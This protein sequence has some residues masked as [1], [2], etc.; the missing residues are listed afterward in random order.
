M[1]SGKIRKSLKGLIDSGRIVT[2]RPK[3]G[4]MV[5]TI[6][7]INTPHFIYGENNSGVGRGPGNPGDV[8]G[9]DKNKGN[10]KGAGDEHADG[11]EVQVDMDEV[12]DALQEEW[13]L[14]DLLPKPSQTFEDIEIKYNDIALIGPNSL[15]HTRRTVQQALKRCCAA[16]DG[17]NLV[18]LPNYNQPIRD[19]KIIKSDQRFRQYKEIRKPSS[20]AVVMFARDWSGSMDA[21]R[22][23]VVSDMCWWL[24]C[25][26]RRYYKRVERMYVGH[27]TNAEECSEEKFYKYRMGGGTVCSSALRIIA[28]Q[29]G[30]RFPPD[31]WNIYVF[32]FTDGDNWGSDNEQFVKILKEEFTPGRVNLVGITQVMPWSYDD[33]VKE[34]VDAEIQKKNLDSKVVKTVSIGSEEV[35]QDDIFRGHSPKIG[36]EDRNRAIKKAIGELLGAKA[37]L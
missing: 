20:N 34:Y 19:L 35:D 24:D 32:Y 11:I 16:G 2:Q 21:F 28:D 9:K 30:N 13:K 23:E 10:S 33:S 5:I 14:P 17:E 8:I 22:C 7:R 26:V 27:D 29:F 6:P 12:L 25:W 4:K 36:D 37:A 18:Q 3:G 31:A 15:R 1:I